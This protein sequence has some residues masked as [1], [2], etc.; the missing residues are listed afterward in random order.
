MRSPFQ[1]KLR[2]PPKNHGW[3]YMN[4]LA[5]IT[6]INILFDPKG[7]FFESLNSRSIVSVEIQIIDPLLVPKIIICSFDSSLEDRKNDLEKS[8]EVMSNNSNLVKIAN[9]Q[10]PIGQN[11]PH[12]EV[13][14][15]QN[16]SAIFWLLVTKLFYSSF[17][18]FPKIVMKMTDRDMIWYL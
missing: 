13:E 9:F 7:S 3:I 17:F 15:R 18:Y 5:Y 10:W 11:W 1:R 4:R 14:F 2:R 8:F 16:F 6:L 12:N